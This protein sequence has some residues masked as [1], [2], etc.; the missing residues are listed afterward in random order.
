MLFIDG[1]MQGQTEWTG[2]I[3]AGEQANIGYVKSNGFHFD[4][5]IAEVEI[6]GHSTLPTR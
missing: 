6:L 4:G 1:R 3:V 5:E 2:A